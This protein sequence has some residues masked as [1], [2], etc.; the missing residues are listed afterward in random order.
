LRRYTYEQMIWGSFM[1][2][3]NVSYMH[4]LG[5]GG[6]GL[7]YPL[8]TCSPIA[9]CRSFVKSQEGRVYIKPEA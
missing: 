7:A 3:E 9:F 5:V 6:V 2:L 8:W 4:G 1:A